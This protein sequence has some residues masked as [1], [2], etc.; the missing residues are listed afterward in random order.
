M[1]PNNNYKRN[2]SRNKNSRNGNS[3]SN[4]KINSFDSVGSEIRVR[5]SAVQ[6]NEKYMALA[7]DAY[8][9]GDRILAESFFQYADHYHRVIMS[10][11][12]GIDPRKNN[13]TTSNSL[14]EKTNPEKVK[15]KTNLEIDKSKINIEESKD[16]ESLNDPSLE[17]VVE[18][19]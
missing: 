12:N 6:V 7:N 13:N 4:S 5:G 10:A 18:K 19:N 1:R 17:N 3:S 9:S 15:D 8:S 2:R 11:N 16:K 14:K